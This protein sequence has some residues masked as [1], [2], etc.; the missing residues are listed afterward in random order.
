MSPA[1]DKKPYDGGG[2]DFGTNYFISIFALF[3]GSLA[4]AAKFGGFGG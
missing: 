1:K 2:A 3:A 4:I